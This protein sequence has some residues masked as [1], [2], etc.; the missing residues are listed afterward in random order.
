[1]YLVRDVLL[2]LMKRLIKLRSSNL[3][4][5]VTSATLDGEKVSRFFS[6][7]PILNVPGKLFPVEIY[8]SSEKPKS[9]IDAC[10]NKALGTVSYHSFGYF[11]LLHFFVSEQYSSPSLLAVFSSSLDSSL[12]ELMLPLQIYTL[13]NPKATS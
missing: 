9:Y 12:R 8:H 6:D 2:G 11:T 5:L 1:M 4:V 13:K 10:L 3:K 7:C